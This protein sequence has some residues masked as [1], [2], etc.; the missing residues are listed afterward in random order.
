MKWNEGQKHAIS[1]IAEGKN[2]NIRAVAG[3]GKSTT[4]AESVKR[5]VEKNN[6][7]AA[8]LMFNVDA[9]SAMRGKLAGVP[10]C[11]VSTLNAYSYAEMIRRYPFIRDSLK[12]FI[13]SGY[14]IRKYDISDYT[15]RS[16]HITFSQEH[17]ALLLREW[18]SEFCKRPDEHFGTGNFPVKVFSEIV[19]GAKYS[20]TELQSIAR[21]LYNHVKPIAL[22]HWNSMWNGEVDSMMHDAYLKK[23]FL[24]GGKI[25]QDACFVDEYQDSNGLGESIYER[26]STLS[27]VGDVFQEIYEFR[28]TGGRSNR[29]KFDEYVD[30]NQS[31]RFG[32]YVAEMSTLIIQEWLGSDMKV[33][34]HPGKTSS[35]MSYD[36]KLSDFD[37]IICRSRAGV[38][39]CAIQLAKSGE[40]LRADGVSFSNMSRLVMNISALQEKKKYDRSTFPA[41]VNS[42]YDLISAYNSGGIQRTSDLGA[43]LSLYDKSGKD[44]SMYVLNRLKNM[45]QSGGTLITT[46]HKS[47]GLEFSKVRVH[48]DYN[49]PFKIDSNGLVKKT[50]KWREEE[51]RLAYVAVSRAID[52]LAT[53]DNFPTKMDS[54]RADKEP[55][56]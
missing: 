32:P 29:I 38:L 22:L 53:P 8:V 42:Y 52:G 3:S 10:G 51:G 37:A 6:S 28:G 48:N 16:S 24:E 12:G 47:K 54:I 40:P 55:C 20:D 17:I 25:S 2:V 36:T 11:K 18:I 35:P 23:W 26:S 14:F 41:G 50:P 46:T 30:M 1:S 15:T 56:F 33:I 21:D 19:V 13:D 7:S 31:Y 43:A 45:E 4:L 5:F 44:S 34:G 27:V 49:A 9:A 39:E